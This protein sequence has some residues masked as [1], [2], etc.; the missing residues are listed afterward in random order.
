MV[1]KTL[2]TMIRI[3][4]RIA[5]ALKQVVFTHGFVFV[6]IIV[7]LPDYVSQGTHLMSIN[8]INKR[9]ISART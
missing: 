6:A 7:V 8:Y 2:A 3:Q 1:F 9:L 4:E 5:L